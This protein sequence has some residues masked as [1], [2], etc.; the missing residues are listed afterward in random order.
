M[1]YSFHEKTEELVD[2]LVSKT[3]VQDRLFFRLLIAYKFSQMA[4]MMRA[5][6]EYAGS[7]NIP[8][9][10]YIMNLADSGFSKGKSINIL[11]DEVF[12]EFRVKFTS[13]F[14]RDKA[15]ES[16]GIIASDRA[17]L[18]GITSD[19]A[20]KIVNKEINTCSKFLYSFSSSTVEGLKSSRLRLSL[21]GAGATCM[22]MDEVGSN[23]QENLPVLA[24]F[25]ETYDMGKAKQKLIKTDS[26]SDVVSGVPSNILMFGTPGK[27]L[28]SSKTEQDF[29]DLMETGYARRLLFGYV[30]NFTRDEE[31]SPEERYEQLIDPTRDVMMKAHSSHFG[32]MCDEDQFNRK[33]TVDRDTAIKLITYEQEC[34]KRAGLLKDHEGVAKAEMSHRYWKALKVAGAYAWVDEKDYIDEELLNNAISLVEESGDAFSQMLNREKPYVKLAKYISGIGRKVTQADLIEDLP[35]YRGSESQKREMLNLSIAY[36]YNNNMII[37]KQIAEGIEFFEGEKL[38]ETNLDDIYCSYSKKFTEGY[39]SMHSKWSQCHELTCADGFQYTA[40]H[41]TDGYRSSEKVIKG[42]N[43]VILDVDHGLPIETAKSLLSEYTYLIATTK[44]HQTTG[45]GD[46][47]RIIMPLSHKL[48]LAP[49]EYKKF[50]TNIFEWL[51]FT[52]DEATADIARKWQSHSGDHWYNEGKLL[53]AMNFIP[54]TTKS[55][56]QRGAIKELGSLDNLQRWFMMNIGEGNRN[57]MLHRYAM[58]LLDNGMKSENI[59]HCLEDFNKQLKDPVDTRELDSTIMKTIIREEVKREG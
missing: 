51:P 2:I 5:T 58:S 7:K 4:T 23:L 39:M 44:R 31:L 57:V 35:F 49:E 52:V 40:H 6:I 26:N 38:Q 1:K 9:N 36:G 24:T 12:N 42:F 18:Y 13:K 11:E 28:D 17:L 47:F 48:D 43:L 30:S 25:L 46:R 10:T 27:L 34:I 54:D 29:F 45:Y 21:S 59:R 14:F 3:G 15:D 8:P 41:W 50:M 32:R 37:K 56:E 33:I 19:D 16:I 53:D 55:E 20:V 22:E